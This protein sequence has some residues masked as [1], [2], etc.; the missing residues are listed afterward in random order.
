M[1]LSNRLVVVFTT[2]CLL[3]PPL[4]TQISKNVSKALFSGDLI[5]H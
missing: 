4:N 3:K 1:L 5:H 2:V